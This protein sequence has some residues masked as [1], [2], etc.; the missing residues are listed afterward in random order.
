MLLLISNKYCEFKKRNMILIVSNK[1]A[2]IVYL[3]IIQFM[4]FK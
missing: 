2:N 3:L 4:T 1:V